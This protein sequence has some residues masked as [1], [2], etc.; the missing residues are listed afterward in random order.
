VQ[1]GE[2]IPSVRWLVLL[3]LAL[4]GCGPGEVPVLREPDAFSDD[5]LDGYTPDDGDCND[6]ASHI[7]PDAPEI[8]DGVD[9]NCD[10]VID[11]GLSCVTVDTFAQEVR[12]DVLFV[13]DNSLS[14]AAEQARL[15]A[16]AAEFLPYAFEE[17][18]VRFDTHLGVITTD[19]DDPEHGGRLVPVDGVR[20]AD[21]SMTVEEAIAWVEAAVFVGTSG[22]AEERVRD[23][24]E[25]AIVSR[26]EAENAGFFRSDAHLEVFVISDEDD[27]FSTLTVGGL[28]DVLIAHSG[29]GNA[30]VNA[31]V[32]PEEGCPDDEVGTTHL[33]LVDL[34]LGTMLPICNASYDGY[35]QGA[36]QEAV[37]SSLQTRFSLSASPNG[38]LTVEV[39]A[40]DGSPAPGSPLDPSEYDYA[41]Q[42]QSVILANPIAAGYS[43]EITYKRFP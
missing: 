17:G 10:T 20:Y 40:P 30:R 19:M 2:E 5:D 38:P 35:L 33:E 34:T 13:I 21:G 4:T 3:G 29:E 8:C 7:H 32:G 1:E 15:R 43:L 24:V 41:E 18:D 6:N 39:L 22:S 23:A 25:A 28:L 31:I 26:Q 11:G 27:T 14:M 9:N 37:L 12:L 16:A 36:S 42:S